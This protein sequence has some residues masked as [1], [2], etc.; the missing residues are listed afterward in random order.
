MKNFTEILT[1][2]NK[3]F[4]VSILK[5][6]QSLTDDNDHC[7]A[8][9]LLAKT[10]KDSKMMNAYLSC[11]SLRDFFGY[12]PDEVY[13]VRSAIDKKMF[14][15]VKKAFSNGQDVYMAF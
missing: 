12:L 11:E 3:A 14:K 8:R 5:K 7:G 13:Q 15:Y 10:I 1:E 4:P 9:V 2:G 6:I